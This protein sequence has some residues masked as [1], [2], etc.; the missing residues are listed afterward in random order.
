[1]RKWMMVLVLSVMLCG[2]AEASIA[3]VLAS[4]WNVVPAVL[5]I[6]NEGIHLICGTVHNALHGLA[7]GLKVDLSST[8]PAPEVPHE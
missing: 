4:A 1:M 2:T 3:G 8:E 6:A 7:N 5:N